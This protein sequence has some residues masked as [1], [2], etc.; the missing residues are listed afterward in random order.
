MTKNAIRKG[1]EERG[2]WLSVEGRT[3]GIFR[4][5]ALEDQGDK[6]L[7][8]EIATECVSCRGTGDSNDSQACANCGGTGKYPRL[9]Q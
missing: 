3:Y 8:E 2:Y 7:A 4:G 9:T 6:T 1:L 5:H